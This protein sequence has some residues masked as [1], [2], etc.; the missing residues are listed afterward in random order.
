[1]SADS[2]A[3]Q[4]GSGDTAKDVE[5]ISAELA[6]LR[7]KL[8]DLSELVEDYAVDTEEGLVRNARRIGSR[9]FDAAEQDA[10]AVME[11]VE[12]NPLAAISIAFALGALVGGFFMARR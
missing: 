3:R 8:H 5:A 6:E 12:A 9:V 10:L 7:D 4:N 11:E 2:N 1:M